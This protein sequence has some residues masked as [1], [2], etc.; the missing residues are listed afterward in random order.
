MRAAQLN[1]FMVPLPADSDPPL[2]RSGPALGE[3]LFD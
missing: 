2:E 1:H 3:A